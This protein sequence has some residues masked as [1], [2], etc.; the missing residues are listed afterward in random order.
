MNA[1]K[2][3]LASKKAISPLI[4]TVLLIG[5][6]VAI[7][8]VVIFWGRSITEEIKG[9]EGPRAE[10]KLS[11]ETSVSIDIQDTSDLSST[12]TDAVS[13]TVENNNEQFIN[14]FTGRI[15]GSDGVSVSKANTPLE[16][17]SSRKLVF[18]YDSSEVGTPETIDIIPLVYV[19]GMSVPCEAQKLTAKIS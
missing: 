2:K 1:R 9:K 18:Y 13:V 14:D 6:V 3:R 5:F 7:A 11:C 4:T 8:V 12:G 15:S 19:E 16:A 17:Y 10:G